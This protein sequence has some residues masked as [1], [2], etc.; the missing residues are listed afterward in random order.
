MGD[1]SN[2]HSRRTVTRRNSS[3]KGE[4]SGDNPSDVT[5]RGKPIAD[6]FPHATVLFA[7]IAGITAW[8][9]SREPSQVF[10]LLESIYNSFDRIATKCN[11]FKVETIVDCYVAAAG[12]PDPRADHASD[13]ARF[14]VLCIHRFREVVRD[15]EV[16]LRPAILDQSQ[17]VS[18][19]AKS[20]GF[21][22]LV[23][24]S[25]W[26]QEWKVREPQI[27]FISHKRVLIWSL[28]NARSFR[29]D[30][31]SISIRSREKAKCKPFSSSLKTNRLKDPILLL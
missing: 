11:V 17:P 8:S 27:T 4:S 28:V 20:L 9:S 29:F 16:T 19:G 15:L 22:C 13:M 10:T 24:L 25:M 12:L 3:S 14:T 1:F 30:H 2:R 21:N 6:L 23:T 31:E 7:N 26:H 18:F 5:R